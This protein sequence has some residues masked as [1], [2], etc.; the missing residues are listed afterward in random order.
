MAEG[1]RTAAA[2][3]SRTAI[4]AFTAAAPFEFRQHNSCARA[5]QRGEAGERYYTGSREFANQVLARE[6]ARFRIVELESRWKCLPRARWG[7]ARFA[8][9]RVLFILP[10]QALGSNVATLLFLHAFAEQR[11]PKAIGVFSARSAADIYFATDLA[12]VYPLWI[13]RRELKEWD[14]VIDLGHLESRRD[15]DIW[16]VDME[17]DLL[18]A[19]GLAP[20]AR[21]AGGPRPLAPAARGRARPRIGILPL[22]SS[23]LRTLPPP[24]TLALAEALA[25]LGDLALSLN[26]N[27]RQGVLYAQALAGRL[28]AGCEVADVY[29][30]IA[31]LMAGIEACDYAV[32]ADSGPA[33]MSKLHG[34]PGVAV[35]SSAPGDVLQGRFT[36]L[37]RWTVPFV[38]PHCA[39]PCGLAK[40]RQTADGRIG[41]M[42]SLGLPLS[43][44]P[45]LPKGGDAAVVDRL[46]R[47]PVPCLASLAANPTPLV[48]FVVADLKALLAGAEAGPQR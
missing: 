42:G 38:G 26:R 3:D 35:Y 28:P 40:L 30:A 31:D 13:S 43:A 2:A 48:D 39:S 41:C 36:N 29:P 14:L 34:T 22:A 33:H 1:A 47:E 27:Q 46:F 20:S 5:L 24:V 12:K 37:R 16:P 8:A 18:A 15:I 17:A 6:P 9:K 19:F 45:G 44:L 21:F 7:E 23:P 10:S 25:P 32:F 4:V 11:R